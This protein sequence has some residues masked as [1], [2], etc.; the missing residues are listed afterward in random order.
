MVS[1][2]IKSIIDLIQKF[3]TEDERYALLEKILWNG[4][5]VPPYEKFQRSIN[6]KDIIIV[7]ENRKVVQ[8]NIVYN[9]LNL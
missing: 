1:K 4:T 2:E 6:A 8:C 7:I 5:V 9:Y 3:P